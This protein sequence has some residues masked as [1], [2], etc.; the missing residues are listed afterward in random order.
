VE[1]AVHNRVGLLLVVVLVLISPILYDA[2]DW[3]RG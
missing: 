2:S 1:A 3:L